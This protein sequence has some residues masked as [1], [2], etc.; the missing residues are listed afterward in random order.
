MD[1]L[2]FIHLQILISLNLTKVELT[3]AISSRNSIC[4]VVLCFV[5]LNGE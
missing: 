3:N 5:F 1:T 2:S 4:I